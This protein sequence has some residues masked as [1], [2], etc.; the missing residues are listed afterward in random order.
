MFHRNKSRMPFSSSQIQTI[1]FIYYVLEKEVQTQSKL[2]A[3]N[4]EHRKVH[5][6]YYENESLLKN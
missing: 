2:S 1:L 5:S 3:N 6:P 4:Q